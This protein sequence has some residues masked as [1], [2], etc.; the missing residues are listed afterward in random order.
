MGSVGQTHS[1]AAEGRR[2]GKGRCTATPPH[3]K[4]EIGAA[5]VGL[6][7]QEGGTDADGRTMRGRRS[8]RHICALSHEWRLRL[9]R[10]DGLLGRRT[11]YIRHDA[12]TKNVTD[13]R[14]RLFER[15]CNCKAKG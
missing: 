9:R 6:D 15:C 1:W 10:W 12:T 8:S 2:E 3:V 4:L 11:C 14:G 5:A 7:R 13:V